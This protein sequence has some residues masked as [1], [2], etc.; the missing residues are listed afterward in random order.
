MTEFQ[1]KISHCGMDSFWANYEIMKHDDPLILL[2]KAV[3]HISDNF[4]GED[5]SAV[6]LYDLACLIL[7]GLDGWKEEKLLKDIKDGKEL[8]GKWKVNDVTRSKERS[9]D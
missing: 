4:V 6:I 5:S 7:W 1:V 9:G 2:N 3:N 8:I